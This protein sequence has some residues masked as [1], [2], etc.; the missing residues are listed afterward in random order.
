MMLAEHEICATLTT[1]N[2]FDTAKGAVIGVIPLSG[3]LCALAV[4]CPGPEYN[5]PKVALF[6]SKLTALS[7][8]KYL[9]LPK[10]TQLVVDPEQ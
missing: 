3:A 7:I 4:S 9:Q 10:I 1:E 2:L 5:T 8:A 6:V